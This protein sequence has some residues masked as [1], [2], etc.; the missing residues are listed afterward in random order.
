MAVSLS[1][2]DTVSQILPNPGNLYLH[3]LLFPIFLQIEIAFQALLDIRPTGEVA[4]E[5]H[6]VGVRS[7][8]RAGVNNKI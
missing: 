1:V 6:Q 2:S 5:I 4:V 3:S 8:P 7:A